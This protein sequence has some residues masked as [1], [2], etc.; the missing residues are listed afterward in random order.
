PIQESPVCRGLAR[1]RPHVEEEAVVR[2]VLV[3]HVTPARD[4]SA[5]ALERDAEVH[6]RVEDG[7]LQ[8]FAQLARGYAAGP[9]LLELAEEPGQRQEVVERRR[10]QVHSAFSYVSA[11]QATRI[12][13]RSYRRV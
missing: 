10:A 4:A 2:L 5:S 12:P 6:G 9:V 3:P 7:A 11:C 8:P 13:T 1:V